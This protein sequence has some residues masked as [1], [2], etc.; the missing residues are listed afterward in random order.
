MKRAVLLMALVLTYTAR[1]D[2]SPTAELDLTAYC[3]QV[4]RKVESGAFKPRFFVDVSD[5]SKKGSHWHEF[6][7]QKLLN[8]ACK[9]G[10]CYQEAWAYFDAGHLILV[11]FTF[12][13]ASAAWA[14]N[15][16]YYFYPNGRVAKDRSELR[17]AN[18]SDPLHPGEAAFLVEVLRLRLYDEHGGKF[19]EAAPQYFK[20]QGG[21]QQS[22][23]TAKFEDALWPDFRKIQDLPMADLLHG[24]GRKAQAA[25]KLP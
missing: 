25:P 15:V 21:S 19:K 9:D 7:D 2:L 16:D 11:A 6:K 14:N 17:R 8:E 20:V 4:A 24:A 22:L 1:A 10:G 12:G 3:D 18:A 23:A 5:G 13:D